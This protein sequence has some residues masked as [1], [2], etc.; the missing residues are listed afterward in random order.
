[1]ELSKAATVQL[2]NELIP[3]MPV[4]Q[5]QTAI[6]PHLQ[7]FATLHFVASGSYQRKVGQDFLSCMSQTSISVSIHAT[8]NALNRIMGQWIQFFEKT[9]FPGII[10]AI[11][12]THIAI[13][14]PNTVR[15][16]LF[17]NRKLYYS[18]N[19]MIV[20]EKLI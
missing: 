20:S 19:V 10:G 12:G 2:I 1:M 11:D 8:I 9:G 13:F 4:V 6:P 3:F 16:H 15:E 5:R 14:A 7:I 17:I 18:L